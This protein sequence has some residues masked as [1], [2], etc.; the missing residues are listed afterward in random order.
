MFRCSY[1]TVSVTSFLSFM[2]MDEVM[3]EECMTPRHASCRIPSTLPCPPPPK[4]K[5]VYVKRRD[6][7]KEGYFQPP[8]LEIIF[9]RREACA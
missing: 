2:S 5:P 4:K 3:E 1:N 6:P 8:D 7:P 9:T